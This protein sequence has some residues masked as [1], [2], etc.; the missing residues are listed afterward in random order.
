[1]KTSVG[2]VLNWLLT[3]SKEQ[4][5]APHAGLHELSVDALH[6]GSRQAVFVVSVADGVNPW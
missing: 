6:V 4:R 1:M 3:R 5:D 2:V